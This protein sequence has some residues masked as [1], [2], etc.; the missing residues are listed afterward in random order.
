M[1]VNF[2]QPSIYALFDA[3]PR[4]LLTFGVSGLATLANT[5]AQQHPGRPVERMSGNPVV[6]RLV[7]ATALGKLKL[8]APA[9]PMAARPRPGCA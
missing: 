8:P 7:A 4:L 3:M 1:A 6:K 5:T 9:K 2:H